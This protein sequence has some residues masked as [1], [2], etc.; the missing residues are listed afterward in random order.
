MPAVPTE[1]IKLYSP[2]VVALHNFTSMIAAFPEGHTEALSKTEETQLFVYLFIFPH[3]SD[4][5]K[6][7]A[8]E[9][10]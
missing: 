5:V 7:R 6:G 8:R 3:I 1:K 10:H 2:V 4:S 9:S